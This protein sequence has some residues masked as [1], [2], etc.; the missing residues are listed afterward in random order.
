[1]KNQKFMSLSRCERQ[2]KLHTVLRRRTNN[3]LTRGQIWRI[4][5]SLPLG[6]QYGVDVFTKPQ[7]FC[8]ALTLDPMY[9]QGKLLLGSA[10]F[11]KRG[12]GQLHQTQTPTV[13]IVTRFGTV[14]PTH[15]LLIYIPPE[16][17]ANKM[18]RRK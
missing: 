11:G 14:K 4:M 1:M 7:D 16:L 6:I 2:Y 13:A 12:P 3:T 15:T 18:R 8:E 9:D 5:Q 17:Y 10:L